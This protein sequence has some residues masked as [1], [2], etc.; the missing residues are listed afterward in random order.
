MA[1]SLSAC[2]GVCWIEKTSDFRFITTNSELE[3]RTTSNIARL[4]DSELQVAVDL[5]DLRASIMDQAYYNTEQR[6]IKQKSNRPLFYALELIE[7]GI[8]AGGSVILNRY[9]NRVRDREGNVIGEQRDVPNWLWGLM[10]APAIDVVFLTIE[11]IK[12]RCFWSFYDNWTTETSTTPWKI[13]KELKLCTPKGGRFLD[14]CTSTRLSQSK[15]NY[16]NSSN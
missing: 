6:K 12:Y 7:S 5:L 4:G 2:S 11:C 8:F 13:G 15:E 3:T 16:E 10:A 14:L 1:G 9:G